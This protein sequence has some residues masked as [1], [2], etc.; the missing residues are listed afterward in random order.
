MPE[1]STLTHCACDTRILNK[2][3]AHTHSNTQSQAHVYSWLAKSAVRVLA[4]LHPFARYL[5]AGCSLL[6]LT[7][8]IAFCSSGCVRVINND[9]RAFRVFIHHTAFSSLAPLQMGMCVRGGCEAIIH[10]ASQLMSSTPPHQRWFLLLDFQNAFNS[11]NRESM[12]EGIR[13][14]IPSLPA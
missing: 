12:F 4:P 11:I 7:R 9:A 10:S 6:Y 1:H 5:H 13:R 14:D 2:T 3:H 8:S